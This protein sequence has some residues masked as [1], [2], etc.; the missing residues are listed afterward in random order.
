MGID[1]GISNQAF[2][3]EEEFKASAPLPLLG[4]HAAYALSDHWSLNGSVEFLQFDIQ[5]YR[6]FISDTRLTVENDT[7]EHFG[8]GI[9][10]NGFKIDGSIDGDNG[11]TADL[12][13]GYQGL[14]LYLRCYF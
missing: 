5:A 13:Y 1:F 12:E 2:S 3:A 11:L 14:M 9:G 6:G 7:F 8:W 4:L 10:F